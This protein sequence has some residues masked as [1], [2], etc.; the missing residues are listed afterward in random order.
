MGVFGGFSY[1]PKYAEGP[2]RL[3]YGGVDEKTKT[4]NTWHDGGCRVESDWKKQKTWEAVRKLFVLTK[5]WC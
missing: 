5:H 1:L 2:K 4:K 3:K